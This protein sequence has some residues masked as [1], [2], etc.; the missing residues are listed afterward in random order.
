MPNAKKLIQKLLP[1]LRLVLAIAIGSVAAPLLA[2]RFVLNPI[3]FL[4]QKDRSHRI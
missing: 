2:L 3:A 1:L 4:K